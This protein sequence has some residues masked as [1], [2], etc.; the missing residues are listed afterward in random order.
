MIGE[1]TLRPSPM[2]PY[3]R[4]E[5]VRRGPRRLETT[6]NSPPQTGRVVACVHV[7]PISGANMRSVYSGRRRHKHPRASYRERKQPTRQRP[8]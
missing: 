6:P 1:L 8:R 4:T 5:C 3:V 2:A 7:N